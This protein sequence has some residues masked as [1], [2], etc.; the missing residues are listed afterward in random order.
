MERSAAN[1]EN[2]G[3][4]DREDDL[5]E[6]YRAVDHALETNPSSDAEL[7]EASTPRLHAVTRSRDLLA[8]GSTSLEDLYPRCRRCQACQ[9]PDCQTIHGAD[10]FSNGCTLCRNDR[11]LLC[12]LR[13]PCASWNEQKIS[14]FEDAR[15]TLK[16]TLQPSLLDCL[17][18]GSPAVQQPGVE[19]KTPQEPKGV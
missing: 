16:I 19:R 8:G 2:P 12:Q 13:K 4:H 7:L 6:G 17:T 10:L 18:G 14:N 11:D 3:G 9:D 15:E 5:D 1:S